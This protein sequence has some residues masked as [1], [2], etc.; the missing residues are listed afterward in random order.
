MKGMVEKMELGLSSRRAFL[1]LAGVVAAAA[2]SPTFV[3]PSVASEAMSAVGDSD[4]VSIGDIEVPAP[5]GWEV[6]TYEDS[7][8]ATKTDENG[9]PTG[10]VFATSED[11]PDEV[12]SA[13]ALDKRLPEM[14]A[15][16][17][18]YYQ[19]VENGFNGSDASV[20][21]ISRAQVGDSVWMHAPASFTDDGY[22]EM[23]MSGYVDAIVSAD[24]VAMVVGFAM[25][26]DDATAEEV[27]GARESITVSGEPMPDE[28]EIVEG[29]GDSDK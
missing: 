28:W 17:L 27:E 9:V 3:S 21:E 23:H 8:Q 6:R 25:D 29:A 2:I 14:F 18:Y 15:V 1:A 22:G 19:I 10:V 26:G 12:I 11:L 16:I 20:G 7:F 24:K 13:S 4:T 5:S